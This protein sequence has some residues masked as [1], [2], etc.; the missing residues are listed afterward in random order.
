MARPV[1]WSPRAIADL[2]AIADYIAS[3]SPSYA[4][5]VVRKVIEST[6]PLDKFPDCGRKVPEFNDDAIRRSV[7]VQLPRHLP[8]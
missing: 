2:E 3:D 7:R 1:V 4:I 5:A 8:C 6:R